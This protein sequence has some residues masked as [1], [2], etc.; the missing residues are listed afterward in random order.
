MDPW[1]LSASTQK[2]HVPREIVT[3][4]EVAPPTL[5]ESLSFPLE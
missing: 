2:V 5:L 3:V 4:V 1:P